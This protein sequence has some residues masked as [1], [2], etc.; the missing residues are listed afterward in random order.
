MAVQVPT[1]RCYYYERSTRGTRIVICIPHQELKRRVRNEDVRK[2]V[3]EDYP[4]GLDFEVSTYEL[5]YYVNKYGL[6]LDLDPDA[7]RAAFLA[8]AEELPEK[9][10]PTGFLP[11]ELLDGFAEQ[12]RGVDPA[13]EISRRASPGGRVAALRR[14]RQ[15]LQRD[16]KEVVAEQ[17]S[18]KGRFPT[19]PKLKMTKG[20]DVAQMLSRLQWGSRKGGG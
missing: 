19:V 2:E 17:I 6:H 7:L 12:A 15:A 20:E 18:P 11:T 9:L 13:K 10:P 5:E 16:L 8:Y 3:L 1:D 14:Q 4:D